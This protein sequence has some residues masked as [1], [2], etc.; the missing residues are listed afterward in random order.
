M[1]NDLVGCI[2]WA[3]V[4][5]ILLYQYSHTP[6]KFY[7]FRIPKKKSDAR[8]SRHIP[9]L[10]SRPLQPFV[11]PLLLLSLPSGPGRRCNTDDSATGG[12][13]LLQLPEF[14]SDP[15][16]R[17]RSDTRHELA[18]DWD[19]VKKQ[20]FWVVLHFEMF[21]Q[22]LIS[23]NYS[24]YS[25]MCESS[26][27]RM[28]MFS[29]TQTHK[30]HTQLLCYTKT[31]GVRILQ[32]AVAAIGKSIV[33]ERVMSQQADKWQQP[34]PPPPVGIGLCCCCCVICSR[35]FPVVQHCL[36][37]AHAMLPVFTFYCV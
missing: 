3:R 13:G 37:N 21:S 29:K 5:K 18:I 10:V 11:L 15:V 30:Q 23:P 33:I 14:S 2:F 20:Q 28:D 22:L 26:L 19:I 24:G 25:D 12:C 17:W 4:N 8:S 16:A 31:Q 27:S 35:Y 9:S 6:S 34:P 32:D 36:H 1:K 7:A